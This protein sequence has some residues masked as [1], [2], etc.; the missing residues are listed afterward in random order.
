MINLLREVILLLTFEIVHVGYV[1]LVKVLKSNKKNSQ[2]KPRRMYPRQVRNSYLWQKYF[3]LLEQ[4]SRYKFDFSSF[5]LYLTVKTFL[6]LNI[7]H[8]FSEHTFRIWKKTQRLT[9]FWVCIPAPLKVRT[10]VNTNMRIQLLTLVMLN[11]LRCTPTLIFNQSDY[12]MIQ[13]VDTN[14]HS[15]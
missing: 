15:N 12:L 8:T 7:V 13:V 3:S 4:I 6:Y 11:K 9:L 5:E 14:S 1:F 2:K 10:V